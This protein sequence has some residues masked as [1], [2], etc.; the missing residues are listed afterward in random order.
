MGASQTLA[1]VNPLPVSGIL[2]NAP[3]LNDGNLNN[4]AFAINFHEVANIGVKIDLQTVDTL[5][6]YT[7]PID[8]LFINETGS[9]RWN[10]YSSDDGANWRLETTNPATSYDQDKSRYQV[11]IG[12][13]QR[14]YLKLVV[15]AWPVTLSV[16]ITEIEAYRN[17]ENTADSN[18]SFTDNQ[19]YSRTLFDVNIR[20]AP[21]TNTSLNYSLV[22]DNTESV[23]G[24]NRER[25]FQTGNINW[26]YNQYFSPSFTINNTT[27]VNSGVEDTSQRT[28]AIN[29]QSIFLPTLETSLG[30]TRNENA[31]DNVLQTANHSVHLGVTAALYPDLD[32]TFEVTTNFNKDEE[33][34]RSTD[35]LGLRWTLTSRLRSSLLVDFIWEHGTNGVSFSDILGD[36][37]SGGQGTLNVNWRPS[38]Q[39]SVQLNGSKGYGEAW[40][41]YDS[42][43]FDTNVTLVRTSKTT[44]IL[45]YRASAAT[46]SVIHGVNANWSWNLSEFFTMQSIASYLVG[47]EES[48]WLINTRLTS[49]F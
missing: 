5:Y 33:L 35:N 44:F 18:S 27:T 36:P 15:T 48:S 17:Q 30:I 14:I 40:A 19:K 34:D 2:P 12:S 1:G 6:V 20:Y 43:L 22:L 46:D 16:P 10:L 47:Q 45:G 25:L 31:T 3:A 42:V 8:P 32:S 4:T 37:A 23:P 49:R 28:Y 24:N 13:L 41:G 11:D 38:D 39:V 9:L 29:I 21:T 26:L 7:G